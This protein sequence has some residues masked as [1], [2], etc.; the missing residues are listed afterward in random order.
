MGETC[1]VPGSRN[2]GPLMVTG[3]LGSVMKESVSAALSLLKSR[4]CE[5]KY[6]IH[7]HFPAGAVP[8]DGPS[9]GVATTM[10]LLSLILDEPLRSDTACTGEITLRGN[11]LPVGGIKEK[12]IAAHRAGIKTV[13]VPEQNR[14]HVQMD[15]PK[16]LLSEINIV[17]LRTIDDA[18]QHFFDSPL[19][20]ERLQQRSPQL[21]I[22]V[23]T[24]GLT[25]GKVSD[26]VWLFD[27]GTVFPFRARL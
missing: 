20:V 23:E 4:G 1:Y 19:R 8:K 25:V 18:A 5:L 12:V 26:D 14:R 15:L 27:Q 9:A 7:V 21:K 3:Q 24:N 16:N 10:A 17:Y 2:E 6:D 13:L 22:A 11:V